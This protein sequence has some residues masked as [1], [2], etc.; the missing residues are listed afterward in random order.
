MSFNEIRFGF[1]GEPGVDLPEEIELIRDP[2]G[3][4][5][6]VVVGNS[7]E[8]S[9]AV[10][11]PEIDFYLRNS[12]DSDEDKSKNLLALYNIRYLKYTYS[13]D[14]PQ[15]KEISTRLLVVGTELEREMFRDRLGED[16]GKF[17]VKEAD[18]EEIDS[19]K[20]YIGEIE[21][22]FLNSDG[23]EKSAKFDQVVWFNAP[24]KA[25]IVGVYDPLRYSMEQVLTSVLSNLENGYEYKKILR[26]DPSICQFHERKHDVC[27]FC[28]DFCPTG[29]IFKVENERHL[30]FEE[31]KCTGCGGC[32]SVCPSG[33]LDYAETSRGVFHLISKV[34]RGKI[35]LIIP[36]GMGIERLDVRLK[37]GVLPLVV[38]G[39]KFLDES[40]LITILQES[41]AQVVLFNDS[42]SR[43]TDEAIKMLNEIYRRRYATDG[44]LA[45]TSKDELVEMIDVADFID[46]SRNEIANQMYDRKREI[47]SKRLKHIVGEKDLGVYKTGEFIHYGMVKIDADKCTLCMSCAG[48]CNVSALVP[49]SMDNTL[50]FRP[51]LCTSCGY[52]ELLCPEE[53]L[54]IEDDV[55]L[56]NPDWFKEKIMAQDELFRCIECGKPF[57]PAKSIKKIAE[58]M[59][60]IFGEDDPR[61]RTLYCCPDCKPK[62]MLKYHLEQERKKS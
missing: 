15:V 50:R 46:G 60:P 6:E 5:R 16:L 59:I 44:I 3:I 21:V 18:P 31:I 29:A 35:A 57:A 11:A 47:F 8:L 24:E 34:F 10:Y 14:I 52:C 45:A 38:G 2:S 33:A 56:L 32:I 49:N 54:E 23:K 12:L 1:F 30:S 7:L 41:G 39:R 42:I 26:Y 43:G 9:P 4:E 55:L 48:G 58:M 51:Y 53:C 27:G 17:E 25:D 22:T 19:I 61:V 20:G 13:T 40:H 28:A 36:E 62:V 37:P